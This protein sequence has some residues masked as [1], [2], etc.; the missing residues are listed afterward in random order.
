MVALRDAQNK[1][2]NLFL[3]PL[4]D[5][6]LQKHGE[7]AR[8]SAP[9]KGN[10]TCSDPECQ[11]SACCSC[12]KGTFV[13][14]YG[15]PK[16]RPFD[17]NV[18]NDES[19]SL[20]APSEEKNSGS[21]YT[22]PHKG[23]SNQIAIFGSASSA[24]TQT[25]SPHGHLVSHKLNTGSTLREMSNT[26]VCPTAVDSQEM[27][28]QHWKQR[29]IRLQAFLKQCDECEEYIHMLRSL[30]AVGRSRHASHLEERAVHLLLEE[31]NYIV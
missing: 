25:C 5:S 15:K 26:T 20:D 3:K 13:Y 9:R 7:I 18:S 23:T 19:L 30:S 22:R 4:A 10:L 12:S 29:F 28:V 24:S 8:L 11:Q 14:A 31:E 27:F 1:H 17:L 21:P 2:D 16:A 6:S